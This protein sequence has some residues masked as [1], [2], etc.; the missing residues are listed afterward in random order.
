MQP[1]DYIKAFATGFAVLALNLLTLVALMFGYGQFIEPGHPTE[2][3]TAAAQRLGA[4]SGPIAGALIIFLFMWLLGRGKPQRNAYA[5]AAA[6]FA[7][8]LVM[9]IA[10]GLTM[11]TPSELFRPAFALSV[12]GVGAAGFAAARICRRT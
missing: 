2:F 6:T 10:L 7:S 1:L 4:W 11:S 3:Y 9:D 5:F 8:Y 12:L